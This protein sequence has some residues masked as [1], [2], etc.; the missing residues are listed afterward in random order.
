MFSSISN[1]PKF[2]NLWLSKDNWPKWNQKIFEVMEMSEL[3]EYL[4]D[5]IPSPDI[6]TDL[7]SFKN[8]TGNNKKIVGFPKSFVVDG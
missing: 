5:K 8:W 3:D 2:S 4:A 6:A 7:A 1:D